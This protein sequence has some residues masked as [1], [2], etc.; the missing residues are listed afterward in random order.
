MGKASGRTSRKRK[1]LSRLI[2]GDNPGNKLTDLVA[3]I[4]VRCLPKTG[5][6]DV[7]VTSRDSNIEITLVLPKGREGRGADGLGVW[8]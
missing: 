6:S 7:M 5:K 1:Y 2:S 3:R 8:G 4:C